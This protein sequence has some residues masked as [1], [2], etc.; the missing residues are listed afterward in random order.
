MSKNITRFT[1]TA[2]FLV[3]T[4]CAPVLAATTDAAQTSGHRAA[5][6]V[7][8]EAKTVA[9][10]PKG[11]SLTVWEAARE[12]DGSLFAQESCNH[13]SADYIVLCRKHVTK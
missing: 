8:T 13:K 3:G 1:L 2:A 7:R 10:T 12:A 4:A 11:E 6:Q 5:V 9:A